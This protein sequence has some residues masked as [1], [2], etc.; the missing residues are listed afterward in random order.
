[1]TT[2]KLKNSKSISSKAFTFALLTTLA[3]A[4]IGSASAFTIIG[5]QLSLGESN[6]DVTSLQS[7]LATMTNVY[8][9]GLVTGYYGSMTA[10]AVSRFQAL[11]GITVTGNVGPETRDKINSLITGG[12]VGTTGANTINSQLDLGESN[13]D[14]TNLQI[15][16]TTMPNLYPSGLVTGYYGSM[17]ASAVSKFQAQYGLAQVGR[18]G[19]QT[20]DKMNS[21]IN[22][23]G[24]VSVS[25]SGPAIY[26]ANQSVTQNS[27]TFSWNTN[28]LATA[29]IYYYT[30]PITMNEGDINSVGFGST[31]GYTAYNDNLARTSQQV[32]IS[33]LQSNTV[34]YYVIVATDLQGNVSVVGPNNT[35]R[36]NI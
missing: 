23:G 24:V 8:P 27:A 25:T 26:A 17:T 12:V 32:T 3:T 6:A 20:R 22:A 36:T 19:P 29:K 4:G 11:Y 18:V 30:S 13:A 7:Y 5:S 35:I 15:F 14:V 10:A 31:N 1:M 34:Y 33:N 9:A 16:L 28:E 21:L 2:F